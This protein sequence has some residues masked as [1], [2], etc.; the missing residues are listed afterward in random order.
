MERKI[1]IQK[2]SKEDT[3]AILSLIT[4]V[5]AGISD[6]TWFA[7]DKDEDFI[8]NLERTGFGLTAVVDGELAGIFIA[9]C[10][11]L[12]DGN[13]G[14]YL[15]LQPE[16][17][18]KVAHMDVAMVRNKYRGLGI[19]RQL[20]KKAEEI[21]KDMGYCYL[22]GTAHP[23]NTYSV[24]NFNKLGYKKVAEALKYGGLP[25]CIFCK[26][27]LLFTPYAITC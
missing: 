11:E 12:G 25:R 13:L 24:N 7:L 4:E 20:M 8:R 16:E 23:D 26:E 5:Y 6:K 15:H 19:Q 3:P 10:T 27:L 2:A 18:L 22:M 14:H 17:L 9:R 21:L 1:V